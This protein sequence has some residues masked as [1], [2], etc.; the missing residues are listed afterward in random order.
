[1]VKRAVSFQPDLKIRSNEYKFFNIF[2]VIMYLQQLMTNK[3]II[4]KAGIK[5]V[6]TIKKLA[7]SVWPYTYKDILSPEQIEYMMELFYSSSS[8]KEQLDKHIFLIAYLNNEPVGFA[9][10]SPALNNQIYKLHKLYVLTSIQGQGLGKTLIDFIVDDLKY[11]G[12]LAL[13]LNVNRGNKAKT[14]YERLGFEVIH[15]EDIDI[16]NDFWMN[17]YVMRLRV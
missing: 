12:G 4:H 2:I 9:S 3:V 7:E 14:F 1:M 10:Y 15:E 8:L 11:R 13:E 5:D 6:A 17:D 16:G